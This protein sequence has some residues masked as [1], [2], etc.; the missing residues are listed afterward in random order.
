MGMGAVIAMY[1]CVFA[2]CLV[3]S[4]RDSGVNSSGAKL[5]I[6]SNPE[7]RFTTAP[8]STANHMLLAVV[9]SP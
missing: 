3:N 2:E 1:R 6:G 4:W 7:P 5:S 9:I 8:S